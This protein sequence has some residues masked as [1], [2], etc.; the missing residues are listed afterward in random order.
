MVMGK[1]FHFECPWCQYRAQVSGGAD[2]GVHCELQT[3]ICRDCRELMDVPTR[4]RQREPEKAMA[5]RPNAFRSRFELPPV[6]LRNGSFHQLNSVIRPLVWQEFKLSCPKDTRHFV[7]PW[8]DPGRCPRCGNYM[9]K[10]G[11]PF[12]LWE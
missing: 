6:V 1:T 12:R 5:H 2:E 3:I 11:W 10:S 7:E 9:E 4:L 8:K